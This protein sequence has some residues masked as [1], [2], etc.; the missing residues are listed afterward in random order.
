M[1]S[2]GI[3]LDSKKNITLNATDNVNIKGKSIEIDGSQ[4]TTVK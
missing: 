1:V 2:D 3:T 4:S